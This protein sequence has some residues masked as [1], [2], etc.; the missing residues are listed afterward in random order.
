M[1]QKEKARGNTFFS[2]RARIL[3]DVSLEELANIWKLS[4]CG[5]MGWQ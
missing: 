1:N 2:F 4:Q 3:A 5:Y